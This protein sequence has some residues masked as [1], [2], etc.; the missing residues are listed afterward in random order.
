MKAMLVLLVLGAVI[1]FGFSLFGG[2]GPAVTLSGERVDVAT[3]D[4]DFRFAKGASFD[5]TYMIFGGGQLDHPNAVT[6]VTL[7]GLS[8][9]HAK[10][11]YDRFPDF[12][13]CA[14][15][16][17]EMAK[18]KVVQVDIVPADERALNQLVSSLGEFEDNLQN[19]GDRVCVRLSG[20]DLSLESA[21]VREAG[22]SVNGMFDTTQ[23]NLVE[24]AEQVDCKSAMG[25]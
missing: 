19:G 10:P 22:E 16:G 24:S 15:P 14:S 25:G 13:R 20:A 23:F 11:I 12:H 3:E 7:A 9:R 8:V 5:E 18:S 2:S 17:A 6:P 21:V 4:L 1:W